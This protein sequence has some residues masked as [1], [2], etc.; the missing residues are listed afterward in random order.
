M[1]KSDAAAAAAAADKW[2]ME[3][4]FVTKLMHNCYNS[5]ERIADTPI[6]VLQIAFNAANRSIGAIV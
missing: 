5:N 3:H 6:L 4:V 2:N 1:E